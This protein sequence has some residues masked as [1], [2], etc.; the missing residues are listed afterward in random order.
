MAALNPLYALLALAHAR[1][2]VAFSTEAAAMRLCTRPTYYSATANGVNGGSHSAQRQTEAHARE[3]LER[4]TARFVLGAMTNALANVCIPLYADVEGRLM[5]ASEKAQVGAGDGSETLKALMGGLKRALLPYARR[6]VLDKAESVH[7]GDR[8]GMGKGAKSLA[9][10][11]QIGDEPSRFWTRF[12]LSATPI[13]DGGEAI[14]RAQKLQ[15]LESLYKTLKV[16]SWAWPRLLEEPT[17]LRV[18]AGMEML[19]LEQTFDEIYGLAPVE[20]SIVPIPT[21]VDYR[22]SQSQDGLLTNLA[23]S[24]FKSPA[25]SASTSTGSTSSSSSDS[26][27][28]SSGGSALFDLP[29]IE[30]VVRSTGVL[31]GETNATRSSPGLRSDVTDMTSGI[32]IAGADDIGIMHGPDLPWVPAGSTEDG[33]APAMELPSYPDQTFSMFSCFLPGTYQGWQGF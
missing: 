9:A 17:A 15:L 3:K 4:G 21:G 1:F 6:I 19:R 18:K 25:T 32:V 30:A 26:A 29:D 16:M 33:F 2:S 14:T 23:G 11:A 28:C 24:R 12:I 5:L 31:C 27:G 13:E 8:D 20:G 7:G 10:F 22:S